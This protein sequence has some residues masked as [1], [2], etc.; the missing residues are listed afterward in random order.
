MLGGLIGG[1]VGY[2]VFGWLLQ[3]GLFAPVIPGA[4]TGLGCGLLSHTDNWIRGLVCALE[5]SLIGVVSEWRL[6]SPP[7][8]TDGSL[9]NYVTQIYKLPPPTLIM[10]GLG[11]FLGFWWGRECTLRG[12]LIR[13]KKE[14]TPNPEI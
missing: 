11:G 8:D 1:V 2:F 13:P 7:F 9:A 14:T 4:V 5:A 10:L 6:L 12:R 3:Y